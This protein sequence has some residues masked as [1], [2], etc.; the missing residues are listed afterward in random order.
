MNTSKLITVLFAALFLSLA[1]V[2]ASNLAFTSPSVT[3]LHGTS[4]SGTIV[5]QNTD[6]SSE[7]Y[8]NITI[9]GANIVF[10]PSS[11][12]LNY[13]A[14]QTVSYSRSIPAYTAASTYTYAF[15]IAG[16]A[17]ASGSVTVTVPT[18]A[19]LSVS[20]SQSIVNSLQNSTTITVTNTGNVALSNVVLNASNSDGLTRSFSLNYLTIA[21][22]SSNSSTLTLSNFENVELGASSA[23]VVIATSASP[24]AT[25]TASLSAENSFCSS[26]DTQSNNLSIRNVNFDNQGSGEDTDWNPLDPIQIEVDVRNMNSDSDNKISTDVEL[27][28]Y[29]AE[30]KAY[31]KLDKVKIG[32]IAGG[33]TETAKFNF[34]VPV[35]VADGSYLYIKAYQDGKESTICTSKLPSGEYK[36]AI[37]ISRETDSEKQ[38][39]AY[40]F[41]FDSLPAICGIDNTLNFKVANIGDTDQRKIKVQVTSP[42]LGLDAYKLL[43]NMNEGDKA[44]SVSFTVAIPNGIVEKKY[45]DIQVKVYYD[46][47][48]DYVESDSRAYDTVNAFMTSVN[49][50][51]TN[52]RSNSTKAVAISASFSPETPKAVIGNQVIIQATIKNS[53]NLSADYTMTVDG[54]SAWSTSTIDPKTF[55]L[56]AGESKT[57]N[58]YLDVNSNAVEGDKEF[59]I[60]ATSGTYSASQKVQITL[61]KGITTDRIINN[62]K[63]N[64]VIYTII[65]VNLILI[66]AIILVVRSLV[67]K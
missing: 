28:L 5:I 6:S 32:K 9:Q 4:A 14:N 45:S 49:V 56:A 2:S 51:G 59:T 52:C 18:S 53:A 3:A 64:W 57:V 12:A 62:L 40:D 58:V 8:T 31:L 29:D 16:N 30:G 65:L 33:D 27:E 38:L 10:S 50:Q 35:D 25:A 66:I 13:L 44:E 1:M 47:N 60:I 43:T 67:R 61:E 17:S 19:S 37:T 22:G 46:F 24:N 26:G 54:N 42:S 20:S 11:F 21:P 55:T 34:T 63:N 48:D 7:N 39:T 15:T 41:N 23:I 36:R